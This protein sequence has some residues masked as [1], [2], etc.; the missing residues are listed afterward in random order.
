MSS[1]VRLKG[2]RISLNEIC[3]YVR[4]ENFFC[5]SIR[6]IK[7]TLTSESSPCQIVHFLLLP[8]QDCPTIIMVSTTVVLISGGNAGIGYEIVKKL[9]YD[10][11]S[12]YHILMGTRPLAKGLKA[13]ES[14]GSPSNVTPIQLDITDDKF[15]STAFNTI[16]ETYGKLDILINNAATGGRDMGNVQGDGF[17][18]EGVSLREV[19]THVYNV[20]VISTAVLTDSMVPL[21]QNSNLPKIMFLSSGLVQ[22]SYSQAERWNTFSVRGTAAPSRQ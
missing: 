21:L 6:L 4:L 15:I 18:A 5:G 20:N 7:P 11:A 19:C 17:R 10:R 8:Q 1:L 16:R 22:L 12:T 14:L 2:F 9:A 3:L 13:L